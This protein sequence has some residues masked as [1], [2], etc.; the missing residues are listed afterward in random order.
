MENSIL[1]NE[2]DLR[3]IMSYICYGNCYGTSWTFWVE[4]DAIVD[5]ENKQKPHLLSILEM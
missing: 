5:G 3:Y 4:G 1:L 2:T